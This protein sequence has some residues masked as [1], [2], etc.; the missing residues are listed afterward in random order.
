MPR[1]VR[2]GLWTGALLVVALL[3]VLAV[4]PAPRARSERGRLPAQVDTSS[5]ESRIDPRLSRVAAALS[6]TR[7]GVRCWSKADWMRRTAEFDWEGGETLGPWSAFAS[8][9]GIELSPEIC[10]ELTRLALRRAPVWTDP[11]PDAL[12]WSVS[13]LAHEAQHVSGIHDEALAECYG[14]QSIAAAARRLGRTPAEGRYLA[15]LFWRRWYP[16][17]RAS[18][19]SPDCRNGGPLDLHPDTNVWP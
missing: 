19:R 7:T 12:A 13:A 2:V 4:V 17:I 8:G 6:G 16:W 9:P 1:L 14:M 10:A 11:R 5:V 15:S 18:Y 3:V